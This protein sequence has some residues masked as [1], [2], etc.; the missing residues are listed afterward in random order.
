MDNMFRSITL[1]NFLY[2]FLLTSCNFIFALITY[3]YVSRVLGVSNIGICNYV[4][5]IITYFVLFSMLGVGSYGVRE[6]A[7]CKDDKDKCSKVFSSL[8]T[9]NLLLSI[10]AISILII[11]TYTIPSLFPYKQFLWIGAIKIFFTVFLVEW[12]FEGLSNFKYITIRSI[13]VRIVYAIA[14]FLFIK[15]END[16]LLYYG[17][18]IATVVVNSFINIT[19]AQRY[20]RFSFLCV[21][22]SGLFLPIL[23]FGLHRI[24]S[25]F[26]NTFSTFYLGST[27]SATQVGF[28]STACKLYGILIMVFSALTTVLVPRV[29]ELIGKNDNNSLQQILEKTLDVI[30]I[31]A[32][33][34]IIFCDIYAPQ[35]IY[36]IAGPGYEG[37]ITPFQ[38]VIS[39]LFISAMQQIVVQQFLLAA[40]NST[41]VLVLSIVGALMAFLLNIILIPRYQA[42][43]SAISLVG[44][45][46]TVLLVGIFYFEKFFEI[47]IP[48]KR[49]CKYVL[50]SIPYGIICTISNTDGFSWQI[51]LCIMLC[52]V[53][54]VILNFYLL[55]SSI[56]KVK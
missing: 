35:I 24:L 34:V 47:N 29:S 54:F 14:V 38:I 40:G 41:S 26:Y 33:P 17:L 31:F 8:L 1:K 28:F 56:L 7:K 32:I 3:P 55:K 45:T 13:F 19:Y 50:Y 5:S 20:V 37:A 51:L 44:S 6:I 43:G 22:F 25:S 18:T 21:S 11:C 36:I 49:I 16:V 46:L 9:I 23:S 53:W 10:V 48:Y 2:N 15:S 42:I 4:D 12:F 27:T 30:L 52:I 39:L